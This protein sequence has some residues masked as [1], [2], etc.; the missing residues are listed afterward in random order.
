MEWNRPICFVRQTNKDEKLINEIIC[1]NP[2]FFQ[3]GNVLLKCP[4]RSSSIKPVIIAPEEEISAKSITHHEV[5]NNS[6][7]LNIIPMKSNKIADD[8]NAIGK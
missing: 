7:L 8:N 1:I 6:L 5:T 2:W 4:I 3:M